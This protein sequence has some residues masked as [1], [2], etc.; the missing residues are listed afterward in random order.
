M[1]RPEPL[2]RPAPRRVLRG[3]AL[4]SPR[5]AAAAAARPRGAG[6]SSASQ[7]SR[8]EGGAVSAARRCEAS[9]GAG[10]DGRVDGVSWVV[11]RW[12]PRKEGRETGKN[13]SPGSGSLGSGQPIDPPAAT[14]A[15]R[16][17]G[18]HPAGGT[19]R[20]S[21]GIQG[22]LCSLLP[23]N[24]Y[25]P[26]KFDGGFL[27]DHS[28]DC[29]LNIYAGTLAQGSRSWAPASLSPLRPSTAPAVG[30][31]QR[32]K[33]RTAAHCSKSEGSAGQANSA[34]AGPWPGTRPQDKG[35]WPSLGQGS[36]RSP[37]VAG[38][39]PLA[40]RH[41]CRAGARQEGS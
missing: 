8:E 36:P 1:Q 33:A 10:R 4:P 20:P 19:C 13:L 5:L 38:G 28:L 34:M 23:L 35:R 22:S 27:I 14:W 41:V 17:L 31:N 2:R 11:W 16:R 6:R 29:G 7:R 26:F 21:G 37:A 12:R 9:R 18:L 32:R 39:S 24:F 40:T 30:S 25:C 3:P 15:A